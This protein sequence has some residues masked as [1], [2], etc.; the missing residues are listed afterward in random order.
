MKSSELRIRLKD[1]RL[2]VRHALK[3]LVLKVG[4]LK[5][6]DELKAIELYKKVNDSLKQ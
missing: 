5:P 3:T 2:I 4:G 1:E 6:Q